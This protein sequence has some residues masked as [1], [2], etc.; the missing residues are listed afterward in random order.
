M[1]QLNVLKMRMRTGEGKVKPMFVCD[2]GLL[3]LSNQAEPRWPQQE[4]REDVF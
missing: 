4:K 2:D 1:F 3:Q